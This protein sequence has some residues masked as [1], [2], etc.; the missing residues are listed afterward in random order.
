MKHSILKDLFHRVSECNDIIKNCKPN[1]E[2]TNKI[3][4]LE[5]K[6]K[7]ILTAKQFKLHEKFIDLIDEDYREEI[8]FYFAEGFKLGLKIGVECFK[9]E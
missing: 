3:C 6:L 4:D 8:D 9:S 7:K 5:D 2:R 1:K